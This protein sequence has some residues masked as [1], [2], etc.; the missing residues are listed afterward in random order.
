[1]GIN[2]TIKKLKK[3]IKH[4]DGTAKKKKNQFCNNKAFPLES[5]GEAKK[6]SNGYQKSIT[7]FLNEFAQ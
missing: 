6:S 5:N 1:M 4:T 3:K 2:I 7:V